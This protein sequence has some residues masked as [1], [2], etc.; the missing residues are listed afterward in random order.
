M[1]IIHRPRQAGK[2]TEIIKRAAEEFLYIIVVNRHEADRVFA[3]A[4]DMGLDIPFPVTI[5]ELMGSKATGIKVNGVAIDNA[6]LILRHI[7]ESWT[8][9]PVKVMSINKEEQ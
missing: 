8:L 9:S 6:E 2:T 5:Q 4:K 7:V 3:Q 1:D